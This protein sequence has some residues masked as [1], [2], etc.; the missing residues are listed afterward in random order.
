MLLS[1]ARVVL[2]DQ[3]QCSPNHIEPTDYSNVR[4]FMSF[5]ILVIILHSRADWQHHEQGIA[6]AL[7]CKYIEID[8]LSRNAS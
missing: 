4:P 6:E 5:Q 8:M 7:P 3:M 2:P 1:Q